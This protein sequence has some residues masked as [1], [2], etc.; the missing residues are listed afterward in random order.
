MKEIKNPR[1]NRTTEPIKN[2]PCLK[3]IKARKTIKKAKIRLVRSYE[4][5]VNQKDDLL[6]KLS[7]FYMDNRYDNRQGS[8]HYMGRLE[9]ATLPRKYTKRLFGADSFH[10]PSYKAANA[11][12]RT[13]KSEPKGNLTEHTQKKVRTETILPHPLP[14]KAGNSQKVKPAEMRAS[15]QPPP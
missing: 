8:E 13:A 12:R 7:R 11:D 9:T 5:S 10:I 2:Q 14:P 1:Y 15:T 6:H 4:R 3:K